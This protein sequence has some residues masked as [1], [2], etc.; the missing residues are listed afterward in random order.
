M[1]HHNAP[2]LFAKND[3]KRRN[4]RRFRKNTEYIKYLA[5]AGQLDAQTQNTL[6]ELFAALFLENEI[7]QRMNNVFS[8]GFSANLR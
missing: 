6:F 1:K 4:L 3:N 2:S 8:R 5:D 7:N